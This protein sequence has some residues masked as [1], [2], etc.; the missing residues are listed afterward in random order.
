MII[1]HQTTNN[2][3]VA[4]LI[5][6]HKSPKQLG[7]LVKRLLHPYASVYIHLDRKVPIGP[8]KQALLEAGID[9]DF[10]PNRYRINWSAFSMVEATLNSFRYISTIGNFDFVNLLSGEDYPLK[11]SA[12]FLTFLTNHWDKSFMEFQKSGDLWWEEAQAR[13]KRYYLNDI[14]WRGKYL[15]EEVVNQL[16]RPRKLPENIA[17]VG[18][19]QWFTLSMSHLRYILENE[20]EVTYLKRFFRYSWA[21][22][23]FFF[24]TLLYN[25]PHRESIINNNLRYINWDEG[26]SSPKILT[27]VDLPVLEA[28]GDFF[29]RKFNLDVDSVVIDRIDEWGI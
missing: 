14:T 24:Q 27:T 13:F 1:N 10:I 2:P 8:F 28:S 20:K 17:I 7:R 26:K 22:D 12:E 11:S 6:A 16:T 21:P 23:E 3:R 18:K 9:A 29:A 5:L 4:H 19:S 25:S 15:L